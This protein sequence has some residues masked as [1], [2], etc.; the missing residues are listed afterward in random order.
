MAN[1]TASILASAIN[2]YLRGMQIKHGMDKDASDQQFQSEQRDAWRAD[3]DRAESERRALVDAAAPANVE[4]G[5][6]GFTKPASADN[7]DVG[8]PGDVGVENGGL[9]KGVTVNG[10]AAPDAKTAGLSAASYNAPEAVAQ[11]QASAYRRIG[12]PVEAAQ[13]ENATLQGQ[14]AKFELSKEQQQYVDEQFDKKIATITSPQQ[15]AQVVSGSPLVQGRQVDVVMSADGKKAQLVSKTDDGMQ[16]KIGEEFDA[17]KN[18]VGKAIIGWS[19]SMKPAE[20]VAGLMHIAQFEEGQRQFQERQKMEESHFQTNKGLQQQQIGI[21]AAHLGIARDELKLHERKLDEDLKNDP[22]RNLPGAVKMSVAGLDKTLSGIDAAITKAQ[23]E[24]QWDPKA[25]GAKDLL[26]RQ[27]QLQNRRQQLLKPYIGGDAATPGAGDYMG[28]RSAQPATPT[29]KA[30]AN[31]PP[32]S[33]S[34]QPGGSYTSTAAGGLPA[35][36]AAAPAAA[37]PAA[38][39]GPQRDPFVAMLNAS[40]NPSLDSVVAPKAE[41]LRGAAVELKKAQ[42]QFLAAA[43]SK[44]PAAIQQAGQAQQAAAAKLEQTA[45]Q[46]TVDAGGTAA[47]FEAVKRQAYQALDTL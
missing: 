22:A 24:G 34:L 15:L 19:Q 43:Q 3:R 9:I 47:Q 7:R 38:P 17:D 20:K 11:R 32:G 41:A 18:G 44:D 45:K 36:P 1:N 21:S 16:V 42:Q 30:I 23:A 46:I 25:A 26:A 33:V 10:Q 5:A 40:G 35:P 28:Y 6:G 27:A 4:E 14:K 39:A 37:A 31:A 2:G 29:G 13:L 12:K 8:Q